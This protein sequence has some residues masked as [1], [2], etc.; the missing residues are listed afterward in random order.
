[1]KYLVDEHRYEFGWRELAISYWQR[2]PN[3]FAPHI[4]SEDT[5]ERRVGTDGRLW[6]RRM[7]LKTNRL[8]SWAERWVTTRWTPVVEESLLDPKLR[9][10][11]TYTRN[12]TYQRVL[13]I[14]EKCTYRPDPANP[15][16]AT[17][18]R[19]EAWIRSSIRGFSGVIQRFGVK[20]FR[21]NITKANSGFTSVL[22]RLF[23]PPAAPPNST[24]S[25]KSRR[26]TSSSSSSTAVA[27][28]L[29]L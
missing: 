9:T 25:S 3:R 5:V 17:L 1:M 18:L 24:P 26:P 8:P 20:R 14:E 22:H 4:L 6:S 2:Y 29:K 11:T 16:A 7:L 27:P 21:D 19:R 10:L 13:S 28:K 15:N 23:P 12:L